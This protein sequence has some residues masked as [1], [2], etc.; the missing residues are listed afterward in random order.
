MMLFLLVSSAVAS[1]RIGDTVE[2]LEARYGKPVGSS[3][4]CTHYEKEGISISVGMWKDH[5]HLIYFRRVY[6]GEDAVKH[7][8]RSPRDLTKEEIES[9]L[10]DNPA[11]VKWD[12]TKGEVMSKDEK[13][14]AYVSPSGVLIQTMVFSRRG[15]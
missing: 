3:G 9:F 8:G 11:G 7:F 4:G 14:T 5:C 1:A 6:S 13:Y 10:T 15:R 2:E 12:G